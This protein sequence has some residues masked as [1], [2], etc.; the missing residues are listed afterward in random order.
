MEIEWP[1]ITIGIITFNRPVEIV[2]TIE[3][4]RAN[5]YYPEDKLH[6]IISDD[7]SP[8]G[9]LA[10]LKKQALFK[11]IGARF[12]DTGINS[13]WGKNANHLLDCVE[14]D[15][16][17]MLEDD[18]VLH[19]PLDLRVGVAA[20]MEMPYIGMMR[21]RGTAG[22][23]LILHHMEVNIEKWMPD[24]QDGV[25]A[26]GHLTYCLLD[27][28]SPAL[29]IYSHGPH[30]KRRNFHE[31]YGRYPEGMK[32]GQTEEAYAH[33]VKDKMR[34]NG[35]PPIGILPEWIPNYFDDIG[36]SYQGSEWDK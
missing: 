1:E 36:Q 22:D 15:F 17:L 8:N 16:H 6:W 2:K 11:D 13:G 10:K 34:E 23:H 20:M 31:F 3:A 32:L 24:Y 29:H 5:L 30:L 12:I 27:C 33:Q 19:H 18:K 21:Y 14:T 26:A 7:A 9:Y 25:G 28:G 35:A 4:L